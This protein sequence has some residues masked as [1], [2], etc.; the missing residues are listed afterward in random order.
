[1]I[2]IKYNSVEE[3]THPN[4]IKRNILVKYILDEYNQIMMLWC[5][6]PVM[7]IQL[8]TSTSKDANG[9]LITSPNYPIIT[10]FND[11]VQQLSLLIV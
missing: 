5:S 10:C 4:M 8:A 2:E 11:M 7:Y 9:I 3:Y 6:V 1:M